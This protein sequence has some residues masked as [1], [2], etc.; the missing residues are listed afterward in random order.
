MGNI[1]I[2]Q[3]A[4]LLAAS[5][6]VVI[7]VLACSAKKKKGQALAQANATNLARKALDDIEFNRREIVMPSGVTQ[8]AMKL[9]IID[10]LL[11]SAEFAEKASREVLETLQAY[12]KY[13][14]AVGTSAMVQRTAG[15]APLVMS[16]VLAEDGRGKFE[17]MSQKAETAL[18]D[19]F[20]AC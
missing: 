3:I 1:P 14:N 13:V 5:A 2:L 8:L 6:I 10:E 20:N 7:V 18:Q 19:Y 15:G 4:V 11:G 9:D 16:R 12:R 17:E